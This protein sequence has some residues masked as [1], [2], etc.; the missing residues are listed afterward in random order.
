MKLM[1]TAVRGRERYHEYLFIISEHILFKR[2]V[3]ALTSTLST[4]EHP[5]RASAHTKSIEEKTDIG[6]EIKEIKRERA[7]FISN[8]IIFQR[9]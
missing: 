5:L 1:E 4:P 3:W 2:K 8:I 9:L 7:I 6:I